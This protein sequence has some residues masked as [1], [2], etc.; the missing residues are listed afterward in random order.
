MIKQKVCRFR[1][2]HLFQSNHGRSH[3]FGRVLRIVKT[4]HPPTPV[5]PYLFVP[6][7]GI[8]MKVGSC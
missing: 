2:A 3:I 6:F 8:F 5:T 1:G 4:H 7:V